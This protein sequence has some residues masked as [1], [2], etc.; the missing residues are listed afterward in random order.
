L[1]TTK[2]R[3]EAIRE[4]IAKRASLA[5]RDVSGI[6][7]L[8]VTKTRTIEE[9]LEAAAFVDGLGEN[10]VQE[11]ASKKN[12]WPALIKVEWRMIGHLQSNKTRKAVALFDA[13]D[14]IDSEDLAR[15]VERIAEEVNVTVPILIE[16]NTSGEASKT[17]VCPE[18][19]PALL[20]RVLDCRRLRLDGLMTIGPL[21]GD[22]S[23]VRGAFAMLRSFAESA[24]SRSGLPLPVLSMGMSDDFEWAVAEG[25][26]MVRIGTSL[27]AP[28]ENRG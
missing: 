15:A 17:G 8:A 16:I 23:R 22:E 24:K 14:S 3:I 28:R 10:R 7:L 4:R 27:F 12:A 13:L 11:A 6:K 5:G 21:I 2:D 1:V 26:T 19:F 25:S 18:D 20:D 9:M